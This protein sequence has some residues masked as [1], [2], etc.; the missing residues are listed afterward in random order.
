MQSLTWLS[1]FRANSIL[2]WIFFTSK[3]TY[4]L[5]VCNPIVIGLAAFSWV[6]HFYPPP[7]PLTTLHYNALQ[8]Y[9]TLHYTTL[10]FT[11]LHYTKLHHTISCTTLHYTT[12]HYII[13]HYTALHY[14]TLHHT[15]F[16]F[17]LC[18]LSCLQQIPGHALVMQQDR[19]FR[20]LASFGNNFLSKFEGAEVNWT[21][22]INNFW[23]YFDF[24]TVI[25]IRF[26]VPLGYC[27]HFA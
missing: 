14:T 10:H 27:E 26:M 23:F 4:S 19:P 21:S 5:S 22:L 17:Y 25:F 13:L 8:H 18:L 20:G 6:S 2:H 24:L 9:T 16:S 3:T 7:L 11:S 12:L 15:N 1:V